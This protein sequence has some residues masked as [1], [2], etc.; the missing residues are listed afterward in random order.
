MRTLL[1]VVLEAQESESRDW[2]IGNGNDP[3]MKLQTWKV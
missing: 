1:L 3:E 2:K